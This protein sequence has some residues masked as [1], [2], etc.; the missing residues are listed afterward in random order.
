MKVYV[1]SSVVLRIVLDQ[2]GA[3][4]G[5]EEWELAVVSELLKV[6]T[7]R[8]LDRLRVKSRATGA[9]LAGKLD[10]LHRVTRSFNVIPIRPA[11]LTRAGSSFPTAV[12]TLDAIH[13]A[14]ALLWI[15]ERDEPLTFLTHEAQQA[16]AA[17]ACGL[18]VRTAP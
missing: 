6:E 14:T 11:V 15:E 10:V 5:P 13:L 18:E 9:Y 7:L 2:P 4:A 3:F 16:L 12:G 17:R 1:D 8:A